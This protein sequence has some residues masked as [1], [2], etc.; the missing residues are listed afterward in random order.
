[1]AVGMVGWGS[2]GGSVG[3][4]GHRKPVVSIADALRGRA[5]S[6]RVAVAPYGAPAG[7]DAVIDSIARHA[8]ACTESRMRSGDHGRAFRRSYRWD[9]V[10]DSIARHAPNHV[11]SLEIT[12][13]PSDAPTGG[14]S[15]L[16]QSRGTHRITHAG[17]R[18]RSRLPTLLRGVH[19]TRTITSSCR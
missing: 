2:G 8:P 6:W 16:I 19:S 12:V 13:A 15:S 9:V 11:G 5:G 18:S 3:S 7:R 14:A 17:E 4:R 1:M 10:I